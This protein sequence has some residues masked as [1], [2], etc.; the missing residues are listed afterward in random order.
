[1]NTGIALLG[2]AAFPAESTATIVTL[3]I[4]VVSV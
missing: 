4:P 3:I 1:M 2:A